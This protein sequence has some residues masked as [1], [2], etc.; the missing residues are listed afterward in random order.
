M[1]IRKLFVLLLTIFTVES[2]SQSFLNATERLDSLNKK[3]NDI[4][5]KIRL[6]E[7]QK[8]KI[9]I[10]VTNLNQ[11]IESMEVLSK[12]NEGVK[13]ITSSNGG[14]VRSKPNLT[15]VD[16]ITVPYLDTII[17]L[18][19]FINPYLKVKYKGKTGYMLKSKI[20]LTDEIQELIDKILI[21]ENPRLARLTN[22]FGNNYARRIIN[23]EYWIGM[24]KEMATESLGKPN[25]I[26]KT[27]GKWG[28]N[29]QWVYNAKRLFLYFENNALK[30]FQD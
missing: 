19:E 27:A 23:G 22:L 24:T 2:Y 5:E 6:L 8:A 26:N 1:Q 30:G 20:V 11:E 16:L 21:S 12:F 28:T 25:R 29:E 14:V 10:Q 18:N 13:T 4:E 15:G 7:M 9:L 3:L 17:V